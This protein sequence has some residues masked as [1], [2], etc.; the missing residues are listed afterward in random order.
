MTWRNILGLAVVVPAATA[1][2]L[3]ARSIAGKWIIAYIAGRPNITANL[4][5]ITTAGSATAKWINPATGSQ[6]VIGTYPVHKPRSFTRPDGWQ[7]AL[8]VATADIS[9]RGQ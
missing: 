9:G 2:L 7:D 1:V 5:R 4:A 3:G 8:L 6:E